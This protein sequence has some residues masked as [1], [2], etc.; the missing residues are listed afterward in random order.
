MRKIIEK[1]MKTLITKIL[2]RFGYVPAPKVPVFEYDVYKVYVERIEK[3]KEELEYYKNMAAN[4]H[5]QLPEL[6]ML[7]TNRID[8]LSKENLRLYK[9]L[10]EH[11]LLWNDDTMPY[12]L[13]YDDDFFAQLD[14]EKYGTH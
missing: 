2:K 8:S 5:G 3:L 14:K 12:I 4:E 9:R 7:A 11:N 6:L 10:K 1:K 13:P